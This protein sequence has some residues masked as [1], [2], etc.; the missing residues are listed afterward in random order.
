MENQINLQEQSIDQPANA[1]KTFQFKTN[2]NCAGC[3]AKVS[4]KLDEA[5]GVCHWDVDLESKEKNL[6]VHSDGISEQ[7]IIKAVKEAGFQIESKNI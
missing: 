2:I 1:G 4:E 3:L 6:T 7:E 5:E